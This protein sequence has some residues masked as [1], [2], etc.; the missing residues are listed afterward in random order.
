MTPLDFLIVFLCIVSAAI[1]F[2]RGFVKEA[3]SLLALLAAIWLAWR[4]GFVVEPYLGEWAGV[5][6]V[7]IWV[8]RVIVFVAVMM[9]G[10]LVAWLLRKLVHHSGLSGT[11]RLLGTAFGFARGVVFVGLGVIALEFMGLD[12]DPAWQ[13]ARLKPHADRVAAAI[14]YYAELGSRYLQEGNLA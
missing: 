13:G 8:A 11:D 6:E 14:R 7:K 10:G 5:P 4:F 12:Q 1:G 9:A 2:W 3:M